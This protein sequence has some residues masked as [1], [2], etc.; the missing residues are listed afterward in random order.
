MPKEKKL[1]F[2][3]GKLLLS[4]DVALLPL[5]CS[6]EVPDLVLLAIK[7]K[8]LKPESIGVVGRSS[9]VRNQGA[10]FE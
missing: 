3:R 5:C 8:I 10:E 4:R 1:F 7:V 2:L 6:F 9:G